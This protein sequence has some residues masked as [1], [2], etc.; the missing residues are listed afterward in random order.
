MQERFHPGV[1][2]RFPK[3]VDTQIFL[4]TSWLLAL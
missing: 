1:V 3:W 4:S 2:R